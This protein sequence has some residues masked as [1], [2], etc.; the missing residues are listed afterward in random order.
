MS[1]A[2]RCLFGRPTEEQQEQTRKWLD[3]ACKRMRKQES[4]RWGFDFELGMP[5]PSLIASENEYKYEALPESMVPEFYR[6]KILTVDTSIASVS[7]LDMSS[8]T[9]TPLSS[10][11][12][13]EREDISLLENNS[14]FEEEE[15]SKEWQFR[16]PPTPRKTPVKRRR[17]EESGTQKLT[18][19][20]AV[21][22]KNSS[23]KKNVIYQPKSRRPTV[24]S[25][26][27]Y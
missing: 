12:T 5:L 19:F 27:P 14:S 21:T 8:T 11:S 4:E 16:E 1:S 13:S 17:T 18:N 23:S 15:V 6:T 25:R 10:P 9:L 7:S 2:R 20:Y 24:S 22:K 3:K 26:S